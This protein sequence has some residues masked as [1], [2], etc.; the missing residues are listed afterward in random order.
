VFAIDSDL[1][2]ITL[3]ESRERLM[4]IP[5]AISVVSAYFNRRMGLVESV[6]SVLNQ[7]VREIDYIIID[8]CSTDG[9]FEELSEIRDP[10]IRLIRNEANIGFTR[11]MIRAVAASRA[12]LVAVHDAGDISYPTRL[13]RQKI[14]LD[15]NQNHV[16]VG[17]I[18]IDHFLK[19]GVKREVK[20]D[21][22]IL[23]QSI[24]SHGEVMF[25]RDAYDKAGGYR[26][27]FY[28]SQDRDLWLRMMRYGNLGRLD[29][30]LYERRLFPD[31]V[32]LSPRKRGAQLVFSNLVAYN[33]I[34]RRKTG[35]EP[36]CSQNAL[37][38]LQ[39]P[40][41]PRYRKASHKLIARL[42]RRGRWRTAR[43]VLSDAPAGM[44]SK[45]QQL[46]FLILNLILGEAKPVAKSQEN[47]GRDAP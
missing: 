30:V 38:L 6:Y 8:D 45:R 2:P 24:F 33:E 7:T 32:Q 20:L 11:S 22:D 37:V 41:F 25:R 13:E 39:Q 14:F 5:P 36:I 44:L 23:W 42:L 35:I 9:T 34:V 47:L 31:G 40:P 28:F 1:L 17:S 27:L 26:S 43:D 21:G 10:R 4:E 18:F 29:E 16:C 3:K 15:Q 46:L 12:P 19:S